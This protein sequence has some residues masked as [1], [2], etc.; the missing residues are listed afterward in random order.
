MVMVTMREGGGHLG[1]GIQSLLFS[2]CQ[3]KVSHVLF[4]PQIADLQNGSERNLAQ[5]IPSGHKNEKNRQ[6]Y[7][8]SRCVCLIVMEVLRAS[9][10]YSQ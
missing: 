10:Q 8:M 4:D 6:K 1:L 2:T 3:V 5:D 9:I 7:F